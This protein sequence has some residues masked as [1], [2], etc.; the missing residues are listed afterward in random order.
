MM[1]NTEK[2]RMIDTK[3]EEHRNRGRRMIDIEE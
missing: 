3:K 2:G 1:M